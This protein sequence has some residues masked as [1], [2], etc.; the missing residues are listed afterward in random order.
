MTAESLRVR[1]ERAIVARLREAADGRPSPKDLAPA[2]AEALVA[3]RVVV[4][5]GEHRDLLRY[6]ED[7]LFGLGPL[8]PLLRDER[9]SE[10][11]VNGARGVWVER[12]GRLEETGI[13]FADD[14]EI[15]V[16]IE[17][18]VAPLGR[19]IDLATPLVDARLPDGSRVQRG[20]LPPGLSYASRRPKLFRIERTRCAGLARVLTAA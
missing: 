3:E 7:R 9:V 18:L 12:D 6:F 5:S 4:P 19:R 1:L 20:F 13:R 2:L 10:V 16:I 8:A 11:M 14:E 15:L 17:R